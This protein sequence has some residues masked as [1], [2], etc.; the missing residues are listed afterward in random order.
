MDDHVIREII[1]EPEQS[2]EAGVNKLVSEGAAR[3]SFEGLQ[4]NQ[5]EAVFLVS[6]ALKNNSTCTV[7]CLRATNLDDL[8]AMAIANTLGENGTLTHLDIAD[9]RLSDDGLA[10]I[11]VALR[12]NRSLLV[13][14]VQ[15]NKH[16]QTGVQAL[17]HAL[18]VNKT[19]VSIV[20]NRND[21]GSSISTDELDRVLIEN[22]LY[23]EAKTK[24]L[25]EKEF[26]DVLKY[27]DQG[28]WKRA[29]LMV[30]GEGRAG[31]TAT[32][33][34]L[35]GRSFKKKIKSTVGAAINESRIYNLP[36][37]DYD[38]RNPMSWNDLTNQLNTHD[39]TSKTAGI[40]ARERVK[41]IL[42]YRENKKPKYYRFNRAA[43]NRNQP[44][45]SEMNI[46]RSES[47]LQTRNSQSSSHTVRERVRNVFN[48]FS[49]KTGSTRRLVRDQSSK[50]FGESNIKAKK[51]DALLLSD[52][53]M[54]QRL[55][56]YRRVDGDIDINGIYET[57]ESIDVTIW[58]YGGQ[59]VF[60]TMHHLFLTEYGIYLLVFNL[61]DIVGKK[62]KESLDYLDF[63]LSSIKLHAPCAPIV[64]VGTFFEKR[65]GVFNVG[66][67]KNNIDLKR[68]NHTLEKELDLSFRLPQIVRNSSG[69][70]GDLSF[71]PISNKTGYGVQVLQTV[72]GKV[73]S[74]Q[75][76]VY[77]NVPL[78]WMRCLEL[79][80]TG[81]DTDT[82]LAHITFD[83]VREIGATLDINTK[84]VEDMLEF[85]HELGV[86]VHFTDTAALK[87]VV[88]LNSQWLIDNL[89]KLIRDDK[90][91]QFTKSEQ[92]EME[93]L[94]LAE[95]IKR[96]NEHALVSQDLIY[97]LFGHSHDDDVQ[98]FLDFGRRMLLLSD[99]KFDNQ[100][101]RMYLVPS[102]LQQPAF[103]SSRIS[104][105][106]K[107]KLWGYSSA[108]DEATEMSTKVSFLLKFGVAFVLD[109]GETLPVGIYERIICVA[110][111]MSGE[112]GNSRTPVLNPSRSDIWF[113]AVSF[114][115]IEK[116]KKSIH[117]YALPEDDSAHRY[118][119]VFK[120]CIVFR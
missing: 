15:D 107:P 10:A 101:E 16:T 85:F 99:W 35:I 75:E 4:I 118:V 39:F 50:N 53:E 14:D 93:K 13:L 97:F 115:H 78:T 51:H 33:R 1:V 32:V 56:K 100:Q 81:S 83:Q 54:T 117:M 45:D 64:I 31:K 23:R 52:D 28:P 6:H 68:V 76:Y 108:K 72:L 77:K 111:G 47:N 119:Y 103:K 63:W 44:V 36:G 11:A 116:G 55:S 120:V 73:L 22:K 84:G 114:L 48:F 109:F 106:W 102:L 46:S 66:K 20:V 38:H 71:F 62:V 91:H 41:S 27:G 25:F 49:Q 82:H 29:K 42:N 69:A 57:N 74:Q 9:N 61:K 40:I 88:T 94:G 8:G 24:P 98:F 21:P 43:S 80:S 110:V 19:I 59:K 60:Y 90:Y 34:S 86:V 89:A 7:L 3:V 87:S 30:V 18:K 79:I 5:N 26:K 17:I 113:G 65:T 92:A 104:K 105:L 112:D 67:T 12:K 58:D 37:D 96:M 95:D 2:F 70:D